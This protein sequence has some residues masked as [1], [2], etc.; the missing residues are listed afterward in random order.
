MCMQ[1][2]PLMTWGWE[3]RSLEQICIQWIKRRREERP[4]LLDDAAKSKLNLTVERKWMDVSRRF[5]SREGLDDIKRPKERVFLGASYPLLWTEEAQ[6]R[7]EG[8]EVRWTEGQT[9]GS[10]DRWSDS[11]SQLCQVPVIHSWKNYV[12]FSVSGDPSVQWGKYWPQTVFERI[13]W[14]TTH[15]VLLTVTWL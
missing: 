8:C 7:E 6:E 9:R 5:W 10:A 12:T 3:S 1:T 4:L 15:S 14:A 11:K 2:T 13:S